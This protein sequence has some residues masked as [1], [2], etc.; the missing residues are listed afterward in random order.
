M[1]LAM[2]W[3]DV[4]G[5]WLMV[6]WVRPYYGWDCRERHMPCVCGAEV[7]VHGPHVDEAGVVPATSGVQV[8]LTLCGLLLRSS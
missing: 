2:I 5:R 4:S 7:A 1:I 3:S 8:G 6:C